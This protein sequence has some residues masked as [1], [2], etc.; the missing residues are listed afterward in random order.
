MHS[1]VF[2]GTGLGDK[3]RFR[4]YVQL[5]FEGGYYSRVATIQGSL[6]FEGGYYS[7]VATI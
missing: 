5:L 2:R 3:E 7:R 4:C 6:L 1:K